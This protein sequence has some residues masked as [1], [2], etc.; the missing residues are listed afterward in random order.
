MMTFFCLLLFVVASKKTEWANK[1]EREKKQ[2]RRREVLE[3]FF[4]F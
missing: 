4:S 1:I 2:K 3:V